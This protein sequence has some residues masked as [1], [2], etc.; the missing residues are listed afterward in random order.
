MKYITNQVAFFLLLTTFWSCSTE[1]P[2][3]E[4]PKEEK[5]NIIIFYVDDLGFGDLSCYGATAVNTPNVDRLAN[6]G[7]RFTDAHSSSATCTPSRYSLLTGNYA[8]RMKAGILP[9]D[10]PLLIRPGTATLPSKLK[11]VGYKTAVVGKWHLG[12]GDGEVDWNTKVSPG[13]AEIGFD[14]SFLLPSTGDRVPSVYVEDQRV[15]GLKDGDTLKVHFTN[16]ARNENPYGN[17]TGISNPEMLR[18]QAD[19]QHSG[20]IVNGVSRIGFMSE[21]EDAWLKD[22]DFP[23]VFTERAESF[24]KENADNPFFLYFSFHD[25]HVPRVP[26]ESF[27]GATDMGPRGDAIVQMDW[28]TGQVMDVLRQNGLEENT[29]VIFTSDN[30]PVLNDGYQDEA[31]DRLGEHKP[32]GPYRG[33]KYSI[34]EGGHRMPTIVYWPAKITEAKVSDALWNQLDLF[35]SL[36]ELTGFAY[37]QRDA[38]DSENVL[39]AILG[40]TKT[41]R[42]EMLEEAFTMGYRKGDWKYIAATDKRKEW[43]SWIKEIKNIEGG[44]S[45]EPQL[46]DLKNDPGEQI[47]LASKF[48]EVTAEL[49][50]LMN[51]VINKSFN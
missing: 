48:P 26:N 2:Q 3:A 43:N 42:K 40:E 31:V 49:D 7:I 38:I 29:L 4:S 12:L 24:I 51:T 30:G 39:S 14:Y 19:F 18:Q 1:K 37:D 36:G 11:E 20:V 44:L 27:V 33:G 45:I 35:S 46:Y 21:A 13:P 9:G 15:V 17:P 23:E 5:P 10:A 50:S 16:D 47:N 28:M 41:G 32:A 25:I 34:Y 6:Y 22:E 8:F